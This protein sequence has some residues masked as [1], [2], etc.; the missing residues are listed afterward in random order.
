LDRGERP[1]QEFQA[2][3]RLKL[4]LRELGRTSRK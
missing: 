3:A 2:G 4:L 1:D